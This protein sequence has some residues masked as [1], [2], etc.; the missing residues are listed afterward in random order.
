MIF[1]HFRIDEQLAKALDRKVWLPS[2]GVSW[3]RATVRGNT[4]T[5]YIGDLAPEL[6]PRLQRYFAAE[7]SSRVSDLMPRILRST[8]DKNR[9]VIGSE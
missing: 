7:I 3:L 5:D 1:E 4:V 9:A 8:T 2:G 6:E